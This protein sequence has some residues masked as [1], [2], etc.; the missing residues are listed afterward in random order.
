MLNTP[1]VLAIPPG[2]KG[3]SLATMYKDLLTKSTFPATLP[4]RLQ[5]Q[6]SFRPFLPSFIYRCILFSLSDFV[7]FPFSFSG[8]S[9][10]ES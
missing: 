1:D 6:I 8:L 2:D 4:N 3:V 10:I 9:D 7:S 5:V